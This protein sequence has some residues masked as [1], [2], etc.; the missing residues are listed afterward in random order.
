[1]LDLLLSVFY[2]ALFASGSN[3]MIGNDGRARRAAGG[4][5]RCSLAK[6]DGYG[7]AREYNTIPLID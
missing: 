2:G 3:R 4:R 7:T 5:R 1:M 6:R